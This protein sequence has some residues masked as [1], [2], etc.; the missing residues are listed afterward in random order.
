[1]TLSQCPLSRRSS[2]ETQD[3][4]VKRP[5]ICVVFGPG[6]SGTPRRCCATRRTRSSEGARSRSKVAAEAVEVTLS[7][8]E[9]AE[10]TAGD[11]EADCCATSGA[12]CRGL[13]QLRHGSKAS[14]ASR[15]KARRRRKAPCHGT[16]VMPARLTRRRPLHWQPPDACR[17]A[18]PADL[19]E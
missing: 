12:G 18:Q 13:E 5:D 15:A 19:P 10:L 3:P 7:D 17:D 2:T 4:S 11:G 1:M 8:G 9:A 14:R 6:C 16:G